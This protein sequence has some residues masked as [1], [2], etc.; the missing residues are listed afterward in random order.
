MGPDT[1][2][3]PVILITASIVIVFM[4]VAASGGGSFECVGACG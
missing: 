2:I 3:W 1:E 4:A